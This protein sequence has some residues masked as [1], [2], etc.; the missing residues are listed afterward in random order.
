MYLNSTTNQTVWDCIVQSLEKQV[1]KVL[2]QLKQLKKTKIMLKK[3]KKLEILNRKTGKLENK[4]SLEI[5][6][7]GINNLNMQNI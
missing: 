3:T 4:N 2:G 7:K 6:Y 5:T 1:K